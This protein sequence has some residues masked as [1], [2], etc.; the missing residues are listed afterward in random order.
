MKNFRLFFTILFLLISLVGIL[1]FAIF[2]P[3]IFFKAAILIKTY[4]WP[5]GISLVLFL[6]LL[7]AGLVSN[8]TRLES[9]LIHNGYFQL[10]IL[11]LFLLTSGLGY[12]WHYS[13][14]PGQIILRLEPKTTR[15]FIHL[16]LKY[17]SA[18]SATID[19]VRAPGVRTSLP[20]GKYTFETLDQDIVY[21]KSD[22][23]L[24]PGETETLI[25]PVALNIRTLAVQ[26]EPTG[27]EIW[28]NG[29]QTSR[30][31]YIFEILTGDT[32]TIELK[33]PGYEG[34]TDT[35]S[36]NENVDLGVISLR[37]L[38]TVWISNQYSDTEYRIY[39]A[40]NKVVFNSV[41]SGKLQLAQGRYRLSYEIGEGQY[42]SKWFSL[43]YNSTVTIP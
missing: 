2:N 37:K 34:Y 30:T 22:V 24:E 27:A 12:F 8:S 33:M 43:N 31:P 28:L 35:L 38:F 14:Q 40:E 20:A 3:A 29:L 5:A 16:G 36:L 42:D 10:A 11:E 39:D 26:T 6:V 41:G 1:L 7:T 25:I 21:F 4:L 18:G 13:Q 19:T 17:D 15:D 23:V 9:S 32:V